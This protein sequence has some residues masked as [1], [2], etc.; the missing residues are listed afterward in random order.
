MNKTLY[1]YAKACG[2]G[3]LTLH[4]ASQ[5]LLLTK[6]LK[7]IETIQDDSRYLIQ[8]FASL[9]I[10]NRS[11]FFPGFCPQENIIFDHLNPREHLTVFAGIKGVHSSQIK[12]MVTHT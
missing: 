6:N 4:V 1:T 2:K 12:H 11:S 5:N 10:L 7:I 3:C 9:V 8:F